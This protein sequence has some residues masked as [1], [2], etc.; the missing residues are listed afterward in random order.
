MNLNPLRQLSRHLSRAFAR[1]GTRYRGA[2]RVAFV[3]LALAALAPHPLESAAPPAGTSIGNQASAT[4]T[5][6]SN[7]PRTATSNVA[8]TIVQQVSSF[9]L[10]TDGQT[11]QSAAG[12]QV[13]FPHTIS[14]TGNGTDTFTL[15][16]TNATGDNFDLTSLA[17][18]A[19]LN[20]DGLPDNNTPITSTGPLVAGATYKFV[21]VGTV[22]S[23]AT[24]AQTANI[25]ITG[26]GTATASP[27]TAA[28][29][30]DTITV[31]AN[32]VV[33]VTHSLSSNSGAAGSGPY[34]V[35]INY[36]NI[37]NVAVTNVNLLN[38]IPAGFTYVTNSARWSILGS[39]TALTDAAGGVQGTVPDTII[40]DF[41]A[42]VA[43]RVTAV[44]ARVLPGVSGNLTFTVNITSGTAAG[45]ISNPVTYTY[46]PGTGTPLGPLSANTTEFTVTQSTGVT[47]SGQTIASATQGST[48]TFTNTVQNTGNGTDS[49]DITLVNTSFPAG[50][51]F[52]LYQSDGNTPLVDV[53]GNGIPDTGPLTTNQTYNVIVKAVLPT[54]SSGAS[55]N[56]T[57]A[58]TAT[59]KTSSA[60]TASANDVLTSVVGNTVDL[61]NGSSGGGGTGPE[62]SAV[63]STSANPNTT[64]RFT[65]SVTNTSGVA[66]SYNLS[67]ST[68]SGFSTTTFPTGWSVVFRDTAEAVI[69]S[70]GVL[71]AGANKTIYVDVTI[72]SGQAPGTNDLYFRVVSPTSGATDRLHDALVVNTVR[73]LALT[74]T[75]NGQVTPGGFVVF[76]HTLVNNGN[77]LEGDGTVSSINLTRS[78]TLSGWSSVIYYD[79]DGDGAIGASDPIITSLSFVSAGG[80]GLAPGESVRILVKVYSPPGTP[81]G[82]IDATTITATTVNG[83]YTTTIPT[84]VSLSDNST[85]ISGDLQLT[86]EQALDANLDGNPDTAYSVAD[87]STGA[88]PGKAIRYRITIKNNGSTP[89]TSVKV[90]DTTPAYTLYT[91]TNPAATTVGSVTT[92]PANGAAGSLQF[93]IG[94]LNPGQ[95]AVVTFGVII[96]Q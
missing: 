65:L 55:V 44:I 7:T 46:D 49:F 78:D 41:G 33:T 70:T 90:Y 34:T 62:V 91:S 67:S 66:D 31:T 42:T 16:V 19:D 80:A 38:V 52:T 20:G 26:V 39:G 28:A 25:V 8:I 68:N 43:G 64:T 63:V 24:A 93:D 87:I 18:Y 86:K 47:L 15:S 96:S 13:F 77:V 57:V 84:V 50:T 81:V 1:A 36:N 4:Y 89:A 3:A 11:K 92:V 5:D 76:S 32:G 85:V 60:S 17:L 37:G 75:Q 10:T 45:K 22:P 51:T 72:P 56:Y 48:V 30:T 73:S 82:T 61:T 54:G 12:A 53:N 94:T 27:A 14:N 88:L 59:S 29:N 79:S 40:Y 71:T 74:A 69:T 83:T 2:I 9:A 23:S 58:V 21:A 95:T 6:S 35:T